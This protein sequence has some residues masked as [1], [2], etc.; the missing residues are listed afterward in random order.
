[1]NVSSKRDLSIVKIVLVITFISLGLILL[2]FNQNPIDLFLGVFFLLIGLYSLI[3]LVK[4]NKS[5]NSY[6]NLTNYDERSEINRLK[7]ADISFKFLFISINTLIVFYAV[8]PVTIE[9]F[10]AFLSPIMAFAFII[11]F[12]YYY[13]NERRIE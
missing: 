12:S 13:W 4:A 3:Y 9:I 10:L 7:A 6:S 5:L 1:M 2:F 11:Y 8:N